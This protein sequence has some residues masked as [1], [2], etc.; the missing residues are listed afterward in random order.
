[1]I[2]VLFVILAIYAVYYFIKNTKQGGVKL[3][4]IGII[5]ILIMIFVAVHDLGGER[6]LN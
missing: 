5:V 1:M 4:I 3:M 6:Q 2:F